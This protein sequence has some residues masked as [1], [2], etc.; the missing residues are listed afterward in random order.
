MLKR[1]LSFL[2]PYF[3]FLGT[4]G[5]F[6]LS[7]SKADLHLYV[8]SFHSK[9]FDFI[10]KYLTFLGDGIF[11]VIVIVVF[12]FVAYKDAIFLACSYALSSL[13][14]QFLKHFVFNDHLRPSKYFEGKAS[15]YYVNGVDLNSYY[16]FPSGHTTTS[17]ALF[18]CLALFSSNRLVKFLCF[19]AAL[20]IAYSRVYLSQHFLEDIYAGS[21]V[22][23]GTTLLLYF[24]LSRLFSTKQ[25]NGSLRNFFSK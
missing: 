4:G 15:L 16:S 5:F 21:L 25:L 2:L 1:N 10:F 12:L 7:Y 8:N 19:C 11:A 18:L 13:L 3:I 6:L 22:G 14:T 23:V 17:F 20:C 9:V 24:I